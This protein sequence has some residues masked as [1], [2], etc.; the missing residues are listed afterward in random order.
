MQ[1]GAGSILCLARGDQVRLLQAKAQA[2]ASTRAHLRR[3]SHDADTACA[4]ITA[5]S[6]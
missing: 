1:H 3:G 4:K 2:A 5:A 6:D